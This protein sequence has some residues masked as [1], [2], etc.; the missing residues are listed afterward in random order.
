[1]ARAYWAV[2]D[3]LE[4]LWLWDA[5]GT[6][7][8]S[9][10]WQTQGRSAL[11]DDLLAALAALASNVVRSG[12]GSVERWVSVNQRS[13]DRTMSMLTAIRRGDSF[14]ITNLTVALRQLRNLALTS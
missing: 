1:V 14:D 13:V 6:L 10:R 12:D 8:R 9:D 4:L 11:R 7:P 2:F 3:R 5:I